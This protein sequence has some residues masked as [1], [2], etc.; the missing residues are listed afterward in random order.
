MERN[1]HLEHKVQMY[2]MYQRNL[3]QKI[4]INFPFIS[5]SK[6]INKYSLYMNTFYQVHEVEYL[7]KLSPEDLK[8]T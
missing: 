4:F 1:N 5:I 2:Q 3:L 7:M 8:L 6:L